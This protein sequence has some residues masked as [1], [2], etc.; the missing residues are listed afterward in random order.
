MLSGLSEIHGTHI[1]KILEQIC[2]GHQWWP[3][4]KVLSSQRWSISLS[5][6]LSFFQN[7]AGM[8]N[9]FYMLNIENRLTVGRLRPEGQLQI[10]LFV[11]FPDGRETHVRQRILCKIWNEFWKENNLK[12]E[13]TNMIM[14]TI[15]SIYIVWKWMDSN[16]L[17]V[18][19]ILIILCKIRGVSSWAPIF[20]Q[21]AHTLVISHSYI[22]LWQ[23]TRGPNL[24]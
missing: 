9:N 22:K 24:E 14:I 4:P 19:V 8:I 21:V 2:D 1:G 16:N 15:L 10:E 7:L 17:I 23:M 5:H 3:A 6:T 18:I 11:G 20:A 13:F 12:T